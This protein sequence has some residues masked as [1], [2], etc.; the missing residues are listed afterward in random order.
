MEKDSGKSGKKNILSGIQEE[1]SSLGG[2]K[3][4]IS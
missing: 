3:S 4:R 1:A 2:D